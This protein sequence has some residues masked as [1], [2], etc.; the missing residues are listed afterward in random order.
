MT[1]DELKEKATALNVEFK[2]NISTADL[3]VLVEDAEIA[4][5]EAK[6]D[7]PAPEDKAVVAQ[8]VEKVSARK[9]AYLMIRCIITPLDPRLAELSNEMYSVGNDLLFVKKV[10]NFGIETLEPAM[11]VN[12]LE[13]KKAL[14]QVKGVSKEGKQI[15][16]KR[17][18]PAFS[19]QR[20]PK[21]TPEELEAF[22]EK[23]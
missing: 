20:L 9:E 17:L 15:V 14:M 10:V 8:A 21:F 11:I 1:R 16:T 19:V 2:G 18:M 12:H 23:K 4:A 13:E 22:L 7:K 3:E 6:Y 5:K